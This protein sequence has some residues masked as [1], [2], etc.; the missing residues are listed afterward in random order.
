MKNKLRTEIENVMN[1][2]RRKKEKGKVRED[3]SSASVIG[4]ILMKNDV[5]CRSYRMR[6]ISGVVS[7]FKVE[8]YNAETKRHRTK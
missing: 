7:A 1:E 3:Y 8:T 2:K 4:N 6:R 5:V